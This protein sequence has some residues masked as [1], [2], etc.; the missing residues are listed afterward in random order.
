VYRA[1]QAPTVFQGVPERMARLPLHAELWL[2]AHDDDSGEPHIHEGSLAV[3]LAGALLLHLWLNE[4]VYVG[5]RWN[6]LHQRFVPEP[7]GL[8]VATGASTGDPLADLAL[9]TIR[10]FTPRTG[11]DFLRSWLRAF[12]DADL[13]GR[14][15]GQLISVGILKQTNR[16]RLLSR[17]RMAYLA[18]EQAWAVRVRA[19][20]RDVVRT[21]HNAARQAA[22]P[23]AGLVEA[24]MQC[25]ALC[26][27]VKVLDLDPQLMA[28]DPG[29]GLGTETVRRQLRHIAWRAERT[30]AIRAVVEA[31]D[32]ARGDLAVVAMG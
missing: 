7:G 20:L 6:E 29:I 27:L 10:Q 28:T 24:D 4:Q 16:S 23:L 18:R 21:E 32:E 14:M 25:A 26:G 19:Y 11:Q 31:V 5:W 17:S 12:A 22:Q 8:A 15:R 3:G 13:Y 30:G 1:G 9:A 2:V